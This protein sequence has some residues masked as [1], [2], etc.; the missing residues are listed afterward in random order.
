VRGLILDN[1]NHTQEIDITGSSTN[2][3]TFPSL[4]PLVEYSFIVSIRAGPF[5]Q[6]QQQ[7]VDGRQ[8]PPIDFITPATG[9]T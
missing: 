1:I 2:V 8:S 3:F 7:V 4:L 9:N 5:Q 6:Q